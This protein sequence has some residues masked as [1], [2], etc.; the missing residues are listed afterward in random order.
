MNRT[1]PSGLS[2]SGHRSFGPSVD[3]PWYDELKCGRDE[4]YT[5]RGKLSHL[6][7]VCICFCFVF[8]FLLCF[9]LSYFVFFCSLVF[10]IFF[11]FFVFFGGVFLFFN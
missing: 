6:C 2:I 7:F 1:M 4:N 3:R 8:S 9:L 11:I 5:K 10:F